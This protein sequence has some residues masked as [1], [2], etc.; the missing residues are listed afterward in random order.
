MKGYQLQTSPFS[1]PTDDGKI[2]EEHFGLTTTGDDEVSIAHMIAPSGWGEP[3]QTPNFDEITLVIS[4]K[5][6]I[7]IEQDTIILK[8]GQSIKVNKN[9]RVQ[10]SNPFDEPCRYISICMPAFS[11]KHV[12][13]ES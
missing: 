12:N 10:Y 7:I 8:A 4:G 11:M 3:F 9:I 13:R 2:I 5:K 6:Q 1:V